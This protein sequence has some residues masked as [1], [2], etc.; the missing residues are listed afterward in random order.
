MNRHDPHSFSSFQPSSWLVVG[1]S[2]L[3]LSRQKRLVNRFVIWQFV[4]LAF[5]SFAIHP[6]TALAEDEVDEVIDF[7]DEL[8]EE[9][10]PE[11][12]SESAP[13]AVD[14]PKE[15]GP[16]EEETPSEEIEEKSAEEEEE[17][18]FGDEVVEQSQGEESSEEESGDDLIMFDELGESQPVENVSF[19]TA[20]YS[21][22][23]SSTAR[24]DAQWEENEDTFELTSSTSMRLEYEPTTSFK[25]VV[26]GLFRHW[27]GVGGVS[28]EA[29]KPPLKKKKMRTSFEVILEEAYLTYRFDWFTLTAGNLITNWG[30][31]ALSQPSNIINPMDRTVIIGPGAG[32]RLAQPTIDLQAA[33]GNW[34]L[35]AIVVPFFR[36]HT[37]W[38]FGRDSGA[39]STDNTVVMRE[40]PLLELLPQML[41]S[42]LIGRIQPL[43]AGLETPDEAIENFSVGGRVRATLAN[44]DLGLGYFFGWDR[45]PY[46]E[47]D[48]SLRSVIKGLPIASFLD[49]GFSPILFGINNAGWLTE[50]TSL[51]K[52]LGTGTPLLKM[53]H[54]RLHSIEFDLAR[55]LGPIGLTIDF[56]FQPAKTH[57]T[58]SL[59]SVRRPTLSGAVGLSWDKL[60]SDDHVLS[61][62]LEG[63]VDWVPGPKASITRA[64]IPKEERGE[65]LGPLLLY[66][67]E[68]AGGL[69]ANILWIAPFWDLRIQVTARSDLSK[70]DFIG[71]VDISRP[72][73]WGLDIAV[74]GVLFYGPSLD[75][76]FS[77]GGLYNRDDALY[78]T[79]SG[80]I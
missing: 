33:L 14:V 15:E 46:I 63:F 6:K 68:V 78:L 4:V 27:L 53:Y 45:E 13:P 60:F 73:V 8:S 76:G 22:N 5:F 9:G 39:L 69:A 16:K 57:T 18:D 25:I 29:P 79:L 70:K 62:T 71:W 20:Q 41:P 12:K 21:G 7:G 52:K 35:Q 80:K 30:A 49:P 50:S 31:T 36:N 43:M 56:L 3:P 37:A 44:T 67:K 38:A 47:M 64:L 10:T 48:S 77:A 74:G 17:I 65:T 26:S 54:R 34:N 61:L 72:F 66:P 32:R 1:S 23:W 42:S 59:Y 55:Y 19:S 58:K 28:K 75:K 24:F 40:F 2:L 51:L 11:P